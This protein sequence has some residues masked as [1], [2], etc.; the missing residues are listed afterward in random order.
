MLET[1]S[2]G[3]SQETER[4][5]PS[6]GHSLSGDSARRDKSGHGRNQTE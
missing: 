4:I 5:R 2:R 6:E 1:A 3:T